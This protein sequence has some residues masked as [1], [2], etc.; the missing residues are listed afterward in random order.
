MKS[1]RIIVTAVL[2]AVTSI[3]AYTQGVG[4][5]KNPSL[6]TEN[7]KVLGSCSL[8][9]ARI[10]KAAKVAG[11]TNASWNVKTQTLTVT[12]APDKVNRDDIQKRVAEVGHDTEKYKASNKA[13]GSLPSCCQYERK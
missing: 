4:I 13:Y 6:K 9:K 5:S 8:C 11:V 2:I 1:V 7:I 12:Y 3:L 10:E